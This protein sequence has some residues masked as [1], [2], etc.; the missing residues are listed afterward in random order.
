MGSKTVL[1]DAAKAY[2]G[3]YSAVVGIPYVG[4]VLAP[5]AGGVAYA[6]VA[7]YETLASAS[8]GA[9]VPSDNMLFNLHKDEW[10]LPSRITSGL[11]G[12]IANGGGGASGIHVGGDLNVHTS[13]PGGA[14]SQNA[15]VGALTR[16]VR[17]G[18]PAIRQA[19]R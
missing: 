17:N 18:N 3:A 10:V 4:P 16:A 6:A 13:M 8:G 5:I 12:L 2:S 14:V 7:A 1:Q 11:D 19:L 9:V 15:M